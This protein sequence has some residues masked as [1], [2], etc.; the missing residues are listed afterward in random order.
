MV[1]SNRFIE[2]IKDQF[3]EK[4]CF[5]SNDGFRDFFYKYIYLPDTVGYKSIKDT[6][7]SSG[8]RNYSV[9]CNFE[10]E[11]R[12]FIKAQKKFVTT[13]LNYNKNF[14]DCN[15]KLNKLRQYHCW[16]QLHYNISIENSGVNDIAR[17]CRWLHQ[18]KLYTNVQL[19]EIIQLVSFYFNDIICLPFSKNEIT[20]KTNK[21]KIPYIMTRNDVSLFFSMV[22][23]IE[24]KLVFYIIYTS[25]LTIR[26]ILEIKISEI[27]FTLNK[28]LIINK[29]HLSSEYLTISPFIRDQIIKLINLESRRDDEALFCPGIPVD[30]G[31][32]KIIQYF[33]QRINM[34]R[35]HRDINI[36]SLQFSLLIIS[37]PDEWLKNLS[38]KVFV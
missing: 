4:L 2:I 10:N 35:L 11:N 24:F 28:I 13:L 25:H 37:W 33:N 17:Y 16:L 20:I 18:R 21:N 27:D 30:E 12:H 1:K 22:A 38:K 31:S 36:S 26:E 34:A 9:F 3:N 8:L 14:S 19:T 5:I 23:S 32:E 7:Q 6:L 29:S 15:R